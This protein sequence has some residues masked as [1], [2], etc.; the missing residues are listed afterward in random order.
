MQ[1]QPLTLTRSFRR[2]V[3]L[4]SAVAA[5][6]VVPAAQV[7]ARPVGS[8]GVSQFAAVA[9]ETAYPAADKTA[10][11][12]PPAFASRVPERTDQVVRTIS[13]GHWCRHTWCTVTQ[14]WRKTAAGRWDMVRRFR[15]TIGPNGFHKTREGDLRAPS[16]IYRIR[17]TFSTRRHPPGAMPWRRRLPTSVVT[18]TP[19]RLYNTWIEQPG[20]TDGNRPSMRYGFIV[21]YNRPRLHPGVGP[22]PV[23]GK[24]FGIFYHTSVPGD[25]WSPTLGCTQVGRPESMRWIVRWLDPE[26]APRVVQD[27]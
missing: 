14:A 18:N 21:N 23:P 15:S 24:G 4:G 5:L 1:R 10:R 11:R 13:S 17:V 16:G 2:R 7:H 3:A 27:L 22:R 8:T 12:E 25:P 20:R 19:R 26:A 6:V 9:P